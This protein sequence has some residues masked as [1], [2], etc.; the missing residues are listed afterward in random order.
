M[1]TTDPS[2]YGSP[3]ANL[4]GVRRGLLAYRIVSARSNP[5]G[6]SYLPLITIK[7][8]D[9]KKVDFRKVSDVPSAR[10]VKLVR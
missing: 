6:G 5:A 3:A 8:I 9:P 4:Q 10:P 2:V 7:V 1:V